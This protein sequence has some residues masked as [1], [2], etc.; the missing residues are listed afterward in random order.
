MPRRT[1]KSEN[2]LTEA[3]RAAK[4]AREVTMQRLMVAL[5]YT[6]IGLSVVGGFVLSFYPQAFGLHETNPAVGFGLA[7]LAVFRLYALRL[8][9]RRQAA[10]ATETVPVTGPAKHRPRRS[11]RRAG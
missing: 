7:A 4:A 1:Q 8:E 9:V 6:I 2:P 3:R 5:A 11:V 10:E